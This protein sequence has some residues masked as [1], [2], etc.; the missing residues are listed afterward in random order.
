M[1]TQGYSTKLYNSILQLFSGNSSRALTAAD[2]YRE[3]CQEG[4]TIN[5]TSIYRNL[6]KLVAE[7]KLLKYV[8]DDGRRASYV[9]KGGNES[10]VEHFHLQ[11]TECGKVIH[12]DCDSMDDFIRHVSMEHG[13]DMSCGSS[14][15]YGKCS[16]CRNKSS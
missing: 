12:L 8:T 2:V 16:E 7:G 14:I 9:Y 10:C 15:L 4:E 1:R 11:C 6:D 5:R 13:F 3:V